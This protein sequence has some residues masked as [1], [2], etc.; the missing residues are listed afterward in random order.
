MKRALCGHVR[1]E[2][3]QS[4]RNVGKPARDCETYSRK[5]DRINFSRWELVLKRRIGSSHRIA[6]NN[7]HNKHGRY[8]VHH[9]HVEYA[10]RRV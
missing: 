2:G 9:V 10:A 3:A 6:S 5:T 4:S 8:Y 1:A 7:Q